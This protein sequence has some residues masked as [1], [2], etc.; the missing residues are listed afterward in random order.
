MENSGWWRNLIIITAMICAVIIYGK[1]CSGGDGQPSVEVRTRTIVRPPDTVYIDR[2]VA[3][4][5]YVPYKIVTQNGDT[6]YNHDTVFTSK[7]F[8]A[9]MDTIIGCNLVKL[10]YR[11][12]E[13]SFENLTFRSCPDTIVLTDTTYRTTTTSTWIEDAIYVA[14]GVAIGLIGGFI[15]GAAR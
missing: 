10:S 9:S 15:V 7:P 13:N 4:K 6:V 8:V 3:K 11:Y 5:V 2:V 14:G 12:P 1:S